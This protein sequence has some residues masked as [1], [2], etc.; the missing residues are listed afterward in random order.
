[1]ALR[2]VHGGGGVTFGQKKKRREDVVLRDG[3]AALPQREEEEPLPV[4]EGFGF[5]ACD[6]ED[7]EVACICG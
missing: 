2:L 4:A 1:M 7:Y 5:S 3:A 6:G